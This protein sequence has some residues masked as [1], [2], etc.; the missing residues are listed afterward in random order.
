MKQLPVGW[1]IGIGNNHLR[2]YRLQSHK[3]YKHCKVLESIIRNLTDRWL[4]CPLRL[5]RSAS[6]QARSACREFSTIDE[7]EQWTWGLPTVHQDIRFSDP[8]C[9]VTVRSSTWLVL[10]CTTSLQMTARLLMLARS[11][12]GA[13]WAR[14]GRRDHRQGRKPG[15]ILGGGRWQTAFGSQLLTRKTGRVETYL[16]Q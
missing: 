7:L 6:V 5:E 2:T 10:Y 12:C 3:S 14:P 13:G 9:L 11:T 15:R 8:S 4:H 16:T 1:C